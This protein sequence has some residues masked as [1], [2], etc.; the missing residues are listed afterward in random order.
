VG[1]GKH[2]DLDVAALL[3]VA[4]D[5][6]G[7]VAERALC[8]APCG[9]HRRRQLARRA[10]D[11]HALAAASCCGLD[12]DRELVLGDV[13]GEVRLRGRLW[14]RLW[15]RLWATAD[16]VVRDDRDSGSDGDLPRPVLAT[17]LVHHR[18]RGADEHQ[19]GI[20]HRAGER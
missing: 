4:L 7:V 13:R 20:D 1:V 2:L 9:H 5:D 19:A 10:D 11:P 16:R 8:L 15:S 6:Q 12:Q 17:H 14:A 18:A 3:D